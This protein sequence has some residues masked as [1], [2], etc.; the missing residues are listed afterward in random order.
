MVLGATLQAGFHSE[1]SNM[2]HCN[3]DRY[4]IV[5]VKGRLGRVS[6][7]FTNGSLKVQPTEGDASVSRSPWS[8]KLVAKARPVVFLP[9]ARRIERLV[10]WGHPAICCTSASAGT[11]SRKYFLTKRAVLRFTLRPSSSPSSIS[12]P[13]NLIRPGVSAGQQAAAGGRDQW[14]G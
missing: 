12:I 14:Q 1:V 4:D 9:T 7:I 6:A 3:F 8:V 2:S 10:V 13:T 5:R 11:S